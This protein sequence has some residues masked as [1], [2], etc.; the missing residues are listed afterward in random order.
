MTTAAMNTTIFPIIREAVPAPR[1]VVIS[2]VPANG[3]KNIQ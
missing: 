3:R 2:V 1:P